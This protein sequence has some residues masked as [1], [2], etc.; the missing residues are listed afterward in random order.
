MPPI[1]HYGVL[2]HFTVKLHE[3]MLRNG[4][5]SRLLEAKRKDPGSFLK[6]IF[7]DPPDCTLSFNGLLP[8]DQGRFLADMIKIPHVACLVDYP[9]EYVTLTK[10]AYTIVTC[11]DKSGVDF[12]KQL[13]FHKAFFLPHAIEPGLM[14]D[15]TKKKEHDVVFLASY[16]DFEGIRAGWKKK[17]PTK[18]RK[19]MEDAAEEAFSEL[20]IPYYKAFVSAL[21]RQMSKGP[22][23][24]TTKV[25][26]IA[27]LQELELFIRGKDRYELVKAVKDAK[28]DLFGAGDDQASWKK[29][30]SK[31]RNIVV[32][33]P[34]P[35]EQ[36]LSI[37]KQSKIVLNSCPWIKEG[38]HERIFAGIACGALVITNENR[39]LAEQFK[40]GESIVFYHPSRFEKANHRINEYLSNDSKREHIVDKGREIVLG[41]HTWDRRVEQL[42]RELPQ[43]LKEMKK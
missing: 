26:F 22:T 27:V 7:S 36:A 20:D 37:M 42:V 38:G 19:A 31:Q 33:D 15:H 34:V 17:F 1:S 11:V 3:A 21:D 30:F 14:P 13:G 2:P 43:Y 24:D 12:F 35:F 41:L 40:D 9:Y 23:I 10:S 25:D 6:A 8:D 16:I 4:V 29:A 39:Y 5:K 28:V 18:I 32:H